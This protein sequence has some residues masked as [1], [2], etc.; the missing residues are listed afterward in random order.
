MQCWM[1]NCNL[2]ES[3]GLSFSKYV[4]NWVVKKVTYFSGS[5]S[6]SW[7]STLGITT[8]CFNAST[9][10]KPSTFCLVSCSWYQALRK[11]WASGLSQFGDQD[12]LTH[13][14]ITVCVGL[15]EAPFATLMAAVWLALIGSL[16]CS[17]TALPPKE[18]LENNG[19]NEGR[20]GKEWLVLLLAGFVTDKLDWVLYSKFVSLVC[21]AF[22]V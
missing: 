17:I 5:P 18:H 16:D 13:W 2:R 20:G 22:S 6:K 11:V 8:T 4:P 9:N 10:S 15:H 1:R 19:P 21:A 7:Y 14:L 3:S 12:S